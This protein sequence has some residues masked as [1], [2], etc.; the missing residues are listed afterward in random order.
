MARKRA[1]KKPAKAARK[2]RRRLVMRLIALALVAAGLVAA[3]FWWEARNW[4]PAEAEWPD[5]GALVGEGDGAVSFA[6]LAGL[7]ADFV[8][9]EASRGAAGSDA[10]FPDNLAAARDA[11]LQVGAVHAYDPCV[12]ADGQSAN[13]VTVV[14]RDAGLLPPVIQLARTSDD[15]AERVTRAAVQSELLTLVNQIEAHAGKPAILAPSEDFEDRYGIAARIERNL[16]L[17]GDRRE[18][19][20]AGRPWLLWT[21]NSALPT[22]AAD[23]PLRW[24]V[25]RP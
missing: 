14:P 10:G 11:G 21:A 9:L 5:Q 1:R 25:V 20:Y 8:Y 24:V 17:E 16:W 4:R 13:F 7:G 18:P 15:C 12:P 22:E 23:K 19:G 2:A 3:W 6:T